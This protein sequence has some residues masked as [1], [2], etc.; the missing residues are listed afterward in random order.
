MEVVGGIFISKVAEYAAELGN[1]EGSHLLDHCVVGKGVVAV[2]AAVAVTFTILLHQSVSIRFNVLD[3]SS[4]G[5]E[6]WHP[7]KAT[8][9]NKTRKRRSERQIFSA[10]GHN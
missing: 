6:Y 2:A 8:A 4:S 7:T 1:L 10:A 3:T 9:N 5:L